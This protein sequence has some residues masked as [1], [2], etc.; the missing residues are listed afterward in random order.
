MRDADKSINR[1]A[2]DICELHHLPTR[3]WPVLI[4]HQIFYKVRKRVVCR[5]DRVNDQ[6]ETDI[7]YI[8]KRIPSDTALKHFEVTFQNDFMNQKSQM[9]NAIKKTLSNQIT[10]D[11]INN[12]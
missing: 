1:H 3:G 2:E 9:T 4:D 8:M 6:T 10:F 7:Y 12:K 5:R 11:T